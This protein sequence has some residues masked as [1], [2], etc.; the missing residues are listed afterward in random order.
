MKQQ[1]SG[2]IRWSVVISVEN[3][4]YARSNSV[5]HRR[6]ADDGGHRG[7]NGKGTRRDERGGEQAEATK[8][9]NQTFVDSIAEGRCRP[10]AARNED[11]QFGSW[12]VLGVVFEQS[13]FVDRRGLAT[14]SN[15][16][17]IR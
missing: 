2:S 3:N 4:H 8:E 9:C 5:N 16:C 12:S 1:C 17:S 10:T 7:E 11:S 15:A 6:N 13:D 14:Q